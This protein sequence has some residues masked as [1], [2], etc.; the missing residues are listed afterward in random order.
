MKRKSRG[1]NRLIAFFIVGT[2][3]LI[4]LA[5]LMGSYFFG[6]IGFLRVMGVKYESYW[7]LCLFLY[8]ALSQSFF[9]RHSLF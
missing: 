8:L 5:I 3:V 1:M 9:Q 7:A 4:I 6:F 2:M